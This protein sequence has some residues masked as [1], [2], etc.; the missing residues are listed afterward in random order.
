MTEYKLQKIILDSNEKDVE[1]IGEIDDDISV[2]P[3]AD[4]MS[5]FDEQ[6]L[7]QDNDKQDLANDRAKFMFEAYKS[8]GDSHMEMGIA[9]FHLQKYSDAIQLFEQATDSYKT[10]FGRIHTMVASSLTN[11]ATCYYEM[12]KYELALMK[13][14]EALT[15][16]QRLYGEKHCHL[17]P[18]L[19]EIGYTHFK[20]EQY[21]R[22][23][24]VFEQAYSLQPNTGDT[25][26]TV[27][28][29]IC[30]HRLSSSSCTIC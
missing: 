19:K 28:I 17:V 24:V 23:L 26:I 5:E 4:I 21:E 1:N 27:M 11:V 18:N 20:M 3:D 25:N 14:E 7:Q 12:G 8:R 15:V 2:L 13:H 30:K 6:Q 16:Q 22:A 10:V 29:N 9:S